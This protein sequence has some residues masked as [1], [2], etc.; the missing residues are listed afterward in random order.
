[1]RVFD[2]S[3][4]TKHLMNIK[5]LV[6]EYREHRIM[7][8]GDFNIDSVRWVADEFD[9]Y[10]LPTYAGTNYNEFLNQMQQLPFYQLSNVTNAFGNVL[11]LVFV[12]E[13]GYFEVVTDQSRIIERVQQ[14]PA[15]VPY[16]ITFTYCGKSTLLNNVRKEVMCYK[17]GHYERM[18]QQIEGINFQ[19]EIN[20]RDIESAFEFFN[21]KI[22]KLMK[23][24]I[25]TKTITVN[26]NKPV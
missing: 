24:N 23:D 1:M 21:Y 18:K 12:S 14:D 4:A 3:V 11:D 10:Y 16:E 19:H 9:Q 20:N 26:E 17:S 22:I 25:P 5:K 6:D 2:Y 7:V 8:L 13:L 15:H